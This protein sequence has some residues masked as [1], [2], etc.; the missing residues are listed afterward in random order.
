MPFCSLSEIAVPL[1]VTKATGSWEKLGGPDLEMGSL[2]FQGS[3][4]LQL[5]AQLGSPVGLGLGDQ[6]LWS[7]QPP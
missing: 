3:A 6:M 4:A 5:A 1:M 2:S 7:S